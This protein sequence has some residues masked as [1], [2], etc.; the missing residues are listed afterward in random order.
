MTSERW[1]FDT[2]VLV[3]L[4]DAKAPE[5]QRLAQGLFRKA[6]DEAQPVVS[7]QVLHEFFV[8]VTRTTKRGLAISEARQFMMSLEKA[9]EVKLIT[10]QVI[11]AATE[12]VEQS[13][14]SFWDSLIIESARA[15][16]VSVLWTEDLQH[17]QRIDG[18]RI[19]NPFT[20]D[21]TLID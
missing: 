20:A 5:K 16:D 10:S 9:V 12:R 2:N 17:D 4:F 21:Y 6:V 11:Y 1:F 3:Y 15:A 7:T 19:R 13:G 18:L 14:F 8:T